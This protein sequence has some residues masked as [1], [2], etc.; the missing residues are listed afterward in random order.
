MCVKLVKLATVI[1]SDPNATTL[2][3]R[4]RSYF[5]H[6]ITPLYPWSKAYNLELIKQ[7]GVKYIFFLIFDLAWPGIELVYVQA[8]ASL[9][10]HIK[11]GFSSK[12]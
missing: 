12:C 9:C 8:Y 10:L 5:F 7:G 3:C 4:G 1:D 11:N 6:C 2:R